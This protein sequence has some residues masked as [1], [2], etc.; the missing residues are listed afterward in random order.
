MALT[1]S[2]VAS[3][4]YPLDLIE[5]DLVRRPVVEFGGSGGLV[6]GDG[7]GV[8]EGAAV[9]QVGGDAG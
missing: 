9:L 4:L 7:L 2:F 5:R 1:L 8:F 6:G 3:D